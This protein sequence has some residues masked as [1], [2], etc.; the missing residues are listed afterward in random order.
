MQHTLRNWLDMREVY[1]ELNGRCNAH[2]R[3]LTRWLP[4]LISCIRQ[5]IGV[6]AVETPQLFRHD[7][8]RRG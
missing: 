2:A 5:L 1:S 3:L 6:D 8:D 7:T 4:Q